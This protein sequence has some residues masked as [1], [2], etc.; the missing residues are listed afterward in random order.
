MAVTYADLV[1]FGF[2][3]VEDN[4]SANVKNQ[5]LSVKKPPI[6]LLSSEDTCLCKEEDFI[7]FAEFS[8]VKGPVALFTVP[9]YVQHNDKID[10]NSFIMRIMSVDYQA[11]LGGRFSIAQD[12]QTLQ[13]YVS[14]G[15]HA[16]VHYFTLNDLHARGFV[17]PL[18]V[19]YVS[20][21]QNKLHRIFPELRERFLKVTE[22]IKVNNR[23]HFKNEISSVL[24]S[25]KGTLSTS[26][27]LHEEPL[28]QKDHS[29]QQ[30]EDFSY[31]YNAVEESL[32]GME[33]TLAALDHWHSALTFRD[34][35]PIPKELQD[36]LSL[37]SSTPSRDRKSVV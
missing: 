27:V 6:P 5:R 21:N 30:Y 16:Y 20:S 28:H 29:T 12:T 32:I 37:V 18:C 2:A 22:F 26:Q 17:R 31:M 23:Q 35:S 36:Y 8:E 19:A 24:L 33:Y 14:H 3:Y 7:V 4:V 34:E 1:A 11:N 10:V 25:M 13:T 9:S 15:R